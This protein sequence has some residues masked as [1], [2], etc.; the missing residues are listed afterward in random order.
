MSSSLTNRL[1]K[2]G[3][4]CLD[5]NGPIEADS[6]SVLRCRECYER[7]WQKREVRKEKRP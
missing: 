7:W 1:T 5:C 3:L 4:L 2:L 6:P